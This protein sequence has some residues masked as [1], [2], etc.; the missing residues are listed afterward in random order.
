MEGCS[1]RLVK[2][3]DLLVGLGCLGIED[4]YMLASLL[5]LE[6]C[7]VGLAGTV[8]EV[9]VAVATSKVGCRNQAARVGEVERVVVQHMMW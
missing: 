3:G 2:L 7:S 4:R 5:N 6:D 1:V 8:T 9:G